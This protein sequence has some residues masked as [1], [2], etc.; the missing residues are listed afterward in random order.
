[1]RLTQILAAATPPHKTFETQPNARGGT[2]RLIDGLGL[3]IWFLSKRKRSRR[4]NHSGEF[5]GNPDVHGIIKVKRLIQTAALDVDRIG[6]PA[7][8]VPQTRAADRAE[9][10]FERMSRCGFA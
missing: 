9:R 4:N 6:M 5:S 8:P 7:A 10:A 3:T 1:M 2:V